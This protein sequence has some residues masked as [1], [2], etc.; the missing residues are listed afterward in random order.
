[1]FSTVL[2]YKVG[3]FD[4]HQWYS[5]TYYRYRYKFTAV[6]YTYTGTAVYH[7]IDYLY[8]H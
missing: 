8:T 4:I 3:M 6:W 2:V 1:M 7:G 5:T